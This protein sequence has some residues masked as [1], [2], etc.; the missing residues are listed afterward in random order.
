MLETVSATV[1]GICFV[2]VFKLFHVQSFVYLFMVTLLSLWDF[3]SLIWDQLSPLAL[4]MQ[5]S[6]HRTTRELPR[7]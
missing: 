6:N 4:R 7:A 5:S 1:F 2:K 3:R